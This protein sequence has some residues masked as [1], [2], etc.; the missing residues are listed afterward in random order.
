MSVSSFRKPGNRPDGSDLKDVGRTR[1]CAASA[2]STPYPG[3]R[4][5]ERQAVSQSA[6]TK[7]S[8]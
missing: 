7:D 3:D 2:A 6:L 8:L 1:R 4:Q 5:G